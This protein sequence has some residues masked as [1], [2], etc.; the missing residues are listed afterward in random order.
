MHH[1]ENFASLCAVIP[2]A[3]SLPPA[4]RRRLRNIQAEV[5]I[6]FGKGLYAH[7]TIKTT[8]KVPATLGWQALSAVRLTCFAH[9]MRIPP[10]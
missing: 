2:Q 8:R 1:H 4:T 6:S 9:D 5:P 10:S 7:A 3:V